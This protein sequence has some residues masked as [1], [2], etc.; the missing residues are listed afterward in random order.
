M[1]EDPATLFLNGDVSDNWPALA[2]D[3]WRATYNTVS[4]GSHRAIP[5][6]VVSVAVSH[7]DLFTALRGVGLM[8]VHFFS[9]S[10]ERRRAALPAAR[11]AASGRCVSSTRQVVQQ[12]CS[13]EEHE[14]V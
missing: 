10:I 6:R 1:V 9:G 5:P 2:L 13:P 7:H 14:S 4:D 8:P 12:A 3:H 11:A